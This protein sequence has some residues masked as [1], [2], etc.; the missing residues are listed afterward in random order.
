MNAREIALDVV[1]RVDR[2][3]LL[4][5][6]LGR[7]LD[8]S[9]LSGR[10]KSFVTDLVYGTVRWQRW[11]DAALAPRL[12]KPEGLPHAVQSVLRI[13]AYERLKRRT[14]AHAVVHA[15]VDV[16]RRQQASMAGLVNAVLRRVEPP[17]INQGV[18]ADAIQASLPTWLYSE[19][20]RALGDES[21]DAALAMR[22]ASPLHLAALRSEAATVLEAEGCSVEP[23]GVPDVLRVRAPK[24]LGDLKAFKDG[25]VQPM[26]PSSMLVTLVSEA[27]PGERLLDLCAG[28]GVKTAQW[29]NR[30]ITVTAVE[31][32]AS[33]GE[34]AKRNLARL[35]VE[36]QHVTHDLTTLPKGIQ[37]ANHVVLDAPCSG[38][39]T[40]RGHPEIAWRLS[41][42]DLEAIVTR[43][44]QLL[45]TAVSLTT[46][47]GTLVYAV[48]SLLAS[49]GPEVVRHA[50]EAHTDLELE[51]IDW[52]RIA[53]DAPIHAAEVGDFILP[54]GGFDGFYVACLKRTAES[55]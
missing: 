32:A 40:L 21:L 18:E 22:E 29:A 17:E 48:C 15:W 50:L 35:G 12:A 25:L 28:R 42:Q 4:S 31:L 53:E 16:V 39:G 44:Q 41:E 11:L 9:N 47:G 30:G 51:T 3:A 55:T 14:P 49:E 8:R 46:A 26:N 52:T 27:R 1:R 45:E 19:F 54:T 36:A 24:R 5:R 2:G 23:S 13:G 43:Q 7:R 10:D 6:E 20:Q 38:S 37:P 33:K 34:Q